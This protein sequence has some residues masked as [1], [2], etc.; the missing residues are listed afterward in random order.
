M[1]M[2]QIEG[3]TSLSALDRRSAEK[4]HLFILVNVFLGSVVTGTAFQQLKKFVDEPSTEYVL[5]SSQ[6]ILLMFRTSCHRTTLCITET[7]F[8]NNG[9]EYHKFT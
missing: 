5:L 1:T 2:S 6:E 8:S 9:Q 3:F 4:Y 7:N